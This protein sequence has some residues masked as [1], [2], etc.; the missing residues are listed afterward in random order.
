MPIF[1]SALSRNSRVCCADTA[2]ELNGLQPEALG[3]DLAI[4]RDAS[5]IT[6]LMA[7]YGGSVA[8]CHREH[9]SGLIQLMSSLYHADFELPHS[10]CDCKDRSR[11]LVGVSGV[12]ELPSWAAADKPADMRMGYA[13]GGLLIPLDGAWIPL[14]SL[15]RSPRRPARAIDRVAHS[16][17]HLFVH[18]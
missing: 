16:N 18:P 2:S 17:E 15:G 5:I 14:G 13:T 9:G 11:H 10:P 6:D 4:L 3:A 1:N 12:Y 7:T 8:F